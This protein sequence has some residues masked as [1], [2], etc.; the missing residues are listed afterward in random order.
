VRRLRTILNNLGRNYR[1]MV[2]KHL[3]H[4]ENINI[5]WVNVR[6]GTPLNASLGQ[7]FLFKA[8]NVLHRVVEHKQTTL[9]PTQLAL[10]T[11][12]NMLT[13][14]GP[15]RFMDERQEWGIKIYQS[16]EQRDKC[17]SPKLVLVN[18]QLQLSESNPS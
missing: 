2:R 13:L 6:W 12:L 17:A 1:I 3:R 11:L 16:I 7:S 15:A 8:T 18:N 9:F 10:Q 14:E 5:G 4:H